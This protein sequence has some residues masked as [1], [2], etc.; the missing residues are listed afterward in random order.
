VFGFFVMPESL[1]Q[2]NRRP[3]ELR[4]A[5]PLGTLLTLR[6]Y[7]MVLGMIS[8][9]FLF[10]LGHHVLPSTWTY[11][12]IEKFQWSESQIGYSFAFVGVL[13]VF[14]QAVLLR[15]VLPVIGQHKAA[16]VGFL[17]CVVAFIGYAFASSGYMLYVFMIPGALQGFVMPSVNA[18]MSSHIPANS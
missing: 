5:N 18:I 9:M 7:P 10:M 1:V 2:E 3:F 4:R 16:I 15:R 13:M 12:T 6:K 8:A 17:S 11:Y 14:T